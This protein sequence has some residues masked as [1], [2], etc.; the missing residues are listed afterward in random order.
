MPDDEIRNILKKYTGVRKNRRHKPG[1]AFENSYY[2]F[3]IC[4]IMDH[5]ETFKD[6]G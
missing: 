2:T 5:L 3:D 6:I 1:R 4:L